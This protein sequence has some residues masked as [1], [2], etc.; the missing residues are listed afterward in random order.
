MSL[1]V[2][3]ACPLMLDGLRVQSRA[4]KHLTILLPCIYGIEPGQIYL[5]GKERVIFIR[6]NK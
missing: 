1:I 6:K 2:L 4:I 5:F 3:M